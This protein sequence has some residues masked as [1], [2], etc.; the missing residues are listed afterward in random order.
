MYLVKDATL[1]LTA[2]CN[3]RCWMCPIDKLK[4]T[5][6]MMDFRLVQKIINENPQLK[7]INLNNWGEPFLY[8]RFFEV[9]NYINAKL[10]DCKI[11]FAT[12]GRLL[13]DSKISAILSRKIYEIQFSVDGV[14]DVYEAIRNCDYPTTRILIEH[15]L[16]RR[17]G[18]ALPRIIIKAVINRDTEKDLENLM[19]E[20]LAK[21]DEIKL[22]P[23][24]Q[25]LK[26]E[27]ACPEPFDKHPVV[28]SD[29]RVVP[30]CADFNGKLTLGHAENN[31]LT[32][33]W[34]N[35]NTHQL[36]IAHTE[37]LFSLPSP[38]NMCGEYKTNLIKERFK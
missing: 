36:R 2:F 5:G 29:G 7:R 35:D 22:Q 32:D 17:A 1:E 33:I 21:V 4:R 6:A 25:L 9:I 13:N 38:C 18:M 31:T 28:L 15:L 37:Q 8:P 26:R 34:N 12:N 27:V 10:P 11:Y 20:W 3:L 24:M 30:C 19:R 14:G 16:E 23:M